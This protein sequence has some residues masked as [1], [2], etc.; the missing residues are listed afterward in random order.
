MYKEPVALKGRNNLNATATS[1]TSQP[2]PF[3]GRTSERN[4]CCGDGFFR[5]TDPTGN[6]ASFQNRDS[7]MTASGF[8]DAFKSSIHSIKHKRSPCRGISKLSTSGREASKENAKLAKPTEIE[9][10]QRKLSVA[11]GQLHASISARKLLE[12]EK[13]QLYESYQHMAKVFE[14]ARINN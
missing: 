14:Q 11:E 4:V 8:D 10:L 12:Q 13:K 5:S 7:E 6:G 2:G 1:S 9:E 3:H